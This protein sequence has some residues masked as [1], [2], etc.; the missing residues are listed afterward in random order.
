MPGCCDSDDDKAIR[1]SGKGDCSAGSQE[2]WLH[3][4]NPYYWLALP[5]SF[6]MLLETHFWLLSQPVCLNF[7]HFPS[8]TKTSFLTPFILC[9]TDGRTESVQTG[10]LHCP[11]IQVRLQPPLRLQP[12]WPVLGDSGLP[13]ST[14]HQARANVTALSETFSLILFIQLLS[15]QVTYSSLPISSQGPP[16]G[17]FPDL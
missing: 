2:G 8:T 13:S 12:Q 11:D 14:P 1:L 7:F 15:H 9:L 17:A 10:S 4:P 6:N 16:W 5:L 3:S